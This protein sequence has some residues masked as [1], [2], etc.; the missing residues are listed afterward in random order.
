MKRKKLFKRYLIVFSVS[1]LIIVTALAATGYSLYKRQLRSEAMSVADEVVAF[2]RWIAKSSVVWVNNLH[3]EFSEY[4]FKSEF[5]EGNTSSTFFA[6]NPALAT[7]ELSKMYSTVTKGTTFRVTSDKFRNP[8]N[9]PDDFELKAINRFKNDKNRPFYEGFEGG[10]YR[11]SQPLKVVKGCLKCH[12][13]PA[14]APKE[15]IEKYGYK[16]FGYK[17]GDIRGVITVNVPE[18]G[19][20]SF[21]TTFNP[22]LY[23]SS[24][25][26]LFVLGFNFVWF[27]NRVMKPI[28]S[29]DAVMNDIKEGNYDNRINLTTNDEFSDIAYTFNETMDKISEY[30]QSEQER[31]QTQSN[32]IQL[33]D[34]VSSASEGDLTSRAPVTADVYGSIADAFN[35]MVEGLSSLLYDVRKSAEMVQTESYRMIDMFKTMS[36]GAENQTAEFKKATGII[37]E[38]IQST[39]DISHKA[40]KAQEVSE[41][42][43]NSTSTGREYVIKSLE[44]IQ[45]IRASTQTINKKMKALSE[46]LLE[47]VTISQLIAEVSSRTNLLAMNA[48][49]EASRAGEHGRGFIVIAEEI[50][51]LADR[52]ADASMQITNIIKAIQAEAG[53]VTAS[54]E[55][56]TDNVEKQTV[57]ANDT[58][59]VFKAIESS[60]SGSNAIVSE[61]YNFTEMQRDLS[62]KVV[63]SMGEVNKISLQTLKVVKDTST[64][65]S[66]LSG[67]SV[68]LI[69]TTSRFKI[70]QTGEQAEQHAE[71]QA[72]EHVEEHGELKKLI[73][74]LK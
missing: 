70:Q 1:I 8:V 52:S 55:E 51:S 16:A 11:Y 12:G 31:N 28:N 7:R 72:G 9:K 44:G 22:Y 17:V 74:E 38:L 40:Q 61:I 48:S 63:H 18:I 25:A 10:F 5:G 47:I 32:V 53:E 6:K 69:D 49:I 67:T 24:V 13:K 29:I 23:G 26:L 46:R 36:K 27:R 37:D 14:D 15:I 71:E 58:S 39:S 34:V 45:L 62:N 68:K 43:A 42:A 30:V 65:S 33:L 57:I 2:R 4:L 60:F 21:F 3:P 66:I 19:F 59:N 20:L 50:R 35:L 54:L 56:E 64:I 73:S 41:S